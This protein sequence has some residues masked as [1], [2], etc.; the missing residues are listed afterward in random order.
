MTLNSGTASC[1]SWLCHRAGL[2]RPDKN[3][4]TFNATLTCSSDAAPF[5]ATSCCPSW[6]LQM[7]GWRFTSR[8]SSCR[9][10]SSTDSISIYKTKKKNTTSTLRRWLHFNRKALVLEK[11]S[12]DVCLIPNLWIDLYL[13]CLLNL[14]FCEQSFTLSVGLMLTLKQNNKV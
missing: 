13:N 9:I 7:E 10:I 8:R 6:R 1:S 14:F 5:R 11:R 4:M 2:E 12:A 3:R